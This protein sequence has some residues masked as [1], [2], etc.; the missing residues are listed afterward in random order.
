MPSH[1]VPAH[2]G[3]VFLATLIVAA[4]GAQPSTPPPSAATSPGNPSGAALASGDPAFAAMLAAAIANAGQPAGDI[5]D[6]L[7]RGE[8]LA[9]MG[10]PTALGS[11]ADAILALVAASESAARSQQPVPSDYGRTSR[12]APN[13]D[14]L[15]PEMI[16]AAFRKFPGLSGEFR[17]YMSGGVKA[18]GYEG[19]ATF[20]ADLGTVSNT[21]TAGALKAL[22]QMH[23][24]IDVVMNGSD[25][26]A[27]FDTD[28][29]N[30]VTDTT[31][32]SSTFT[33]TTRTTMAGELDACPNAA[34]L[35]PASLEITHDEDA[36]TF[37]AAGG[38]GGS[39][40]TGHSQSSSQFQGTVDDT[41]T[42]GRVSQTYAHEEKFR[43]S[44][45]ADGPSTKEGSLS[46]G[47]SGI[48]DGVPTSNDSIGARFGDWSGATQTKAEL[49]GDASKDLIDRL[50]FDAGYAWATMEASYF[51]AQEVWRDSR[52]VIVTAPDYIAASEFAFNR[53]PTHTEEVDKGSTTQFQIGLDH[54]YQQAVTAKITA[55]LDGKESLSPD[56]IQKPPG[57]LTYV[58]PDSDGKD[59]TVLLE[60]G[61]PTRDRPAQAHVPHGH[62]QVAGVDQRHDDQ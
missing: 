58:A 53:K 6:D 19:P 5:G 59:A 54:R 43:R 37:A 18:I 12:A 57:Q 39:H 62:P 2:R 52:C 31:T 3:L 17:A 55:K 23:T 42:L 28:V 9:A 21:Q 4:C 33:E 22:T 48:N 29:H 26:K 7:D 60:I 10:V 61:L 13:I 20:H 27:T 38:Q 8:L 50:P 24:I 14:P 1:R 45:T 35:V 34:G 15:A 47:L 44:A 51:A 56:L 11:D 16:L 25:V 49:S 46:F 36:T 32:G 40:A 30:S 41:A